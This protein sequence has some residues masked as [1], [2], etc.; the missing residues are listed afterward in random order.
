MHLELL[1]KLQEKAGNPT[2]MPDN[3]PS[4]DIDFTSLEAEEIAPA[5]RAAIADFQYQAPEHTATFIRSLITNLYQE[6]ETIAK[7]DAPDTDDRLIAV[8]EMRHT[9]CNMLDNLK[10]STD[11]VAAFDKSMNE[12][13][14]TPQKEVYLLGKPDKTE[15]YIN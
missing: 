7:E 2:N 10:K 9:L 8:E 15:R 14:T 11:P 1:L 6:A 13:F 12:K 5:I 3:T 4:I